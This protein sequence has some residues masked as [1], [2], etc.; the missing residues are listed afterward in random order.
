MNWQIKEYMFC[1]LCDSSFSLAPPIKRKEFLFLC[2]KC[3]KFHTK[4]VS[5]QNKRKNKTSSLQISE[6]IECLKKFNF[7]CSTCFLH[8][9]YLT[10]DHIVPMFR[11]GLNNLCNLQPL[12]KDCHEVKGMIESKERGNKKKRLEAIEIRKSYYDNQKV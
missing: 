2:D 11:G 1:K 3:L 10:L 8:T 6:W 5:E 9:K 12:C 4:K 7:K